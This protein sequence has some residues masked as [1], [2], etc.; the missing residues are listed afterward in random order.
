MIGDL[1]G[2]ARKVSLAGLEMHRMSGGYH[3]LVVQRNGVTI[4]VIP[5]DVKWAKAKGN[6]VYG[7]IESYTY[8]DGVSSRTG[9]FVYDS[10]SSVLVDGISEERQRELIEKK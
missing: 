1:L 10:A 5:A 7:F 8:S 9:Y 6:L 3:N 4:E 2:C